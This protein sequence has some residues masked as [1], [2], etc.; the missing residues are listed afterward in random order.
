MAITPSG[1]PSMLQVPF[2]RR[3]GFVGNAG[4]LMLHS[5]SFF[6][7]LRQGPH[8][9]AAAVFI[10]VLTALSAVQALSVSGAPTAV[11]NWAAALVAI[12]RLVLS[13]LLQAILLS[14]VTLFQGAAPRFGLNWR[15]AVWASLPLGLMAGVQLLYRSG[16]GV[17]GEPGLVGFLD[18]LP[19][20]VDAPEFLQRVM[21]SLASNLTLFWLWHLVLLYLGGRYTLKGSPWASLVV[22]IMW[23]LIV[24]LLPVITN[25]I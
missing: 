1:P 16:G 2:R 6:V 3:R 17:I 18:A 10:L 19:V 22:V 13:W 15:I 7:A 20:Y 11:D 14:E 5:P 21:R 9:G 23:V 4:Q 25:Q 24:I 12:T 8:W